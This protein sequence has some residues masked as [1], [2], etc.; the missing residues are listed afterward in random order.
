MAGWVS[1]CHSWYFIKTTKPI[2]ELFQPSGS[3][4]IEAFGIPCADTKFQG[5]PLQWRIK[6]MGL[7]KLAIFDDIYIGIYI[8]VMVLDRLM[9][10]MEH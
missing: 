1:V 10:T 9:V 3:P 8:A 2:L 6:Y 7:R 4:I 5:E